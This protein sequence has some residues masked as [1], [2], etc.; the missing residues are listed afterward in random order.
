MGPGESRG[1]GPPPEAAWSGFREQFV[2][3]VFVR[4][5]RSKALSPDPEAGSRR[6][7]RPSLA[8]HDRRDGV[9]A[10]DPARCVLRVAVL[11]RGCAR[12]AQ[13]RGLPGPLLGAPVAHGPPTQRQGPPPL[14]GLAALTAPLDARK[15]PGQGKS[16][17]RGRRSVGAAGAPCQPRAAHHP[18][19]HVPAR[20]PRHEPV[21]ARPGIALPRACARP[22]PAGSAASPAPRAPR[23]CVGSASAMADCRSRPRTP[24]CS[25]PVTGPRPPADI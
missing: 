3:V 20:R 5:A 1:S 21:S 8:P 16:V 9:R 14:D 18:A 13:L 4:C 10:L 22:A 15:G 12:R 11:Q 6:R 17:R 7:A 19:G 2:K 25:A 24:P 23:P